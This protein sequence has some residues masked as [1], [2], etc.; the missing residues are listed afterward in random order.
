MLLIEFDHDSM[1]EPSERQVADLGSTVEWKLRYVHFEADVTLAADGFDTEN[2][3]VPVLDF[4]YCLLLSARAIR[5]GEDGRVTFTESDVV[6]DFVRDGSD[7]K[8]LRSW[9]PAPGHCGTDEFIA[10]V[11]RFT[12]DA[13]EFITGKYPAFCKNPTFQKLMTMMGPSVS[14]NHGRL[15][16]S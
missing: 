10:A 5:A 12:T 7:L 16:G 14:S 15:D 9:D 3:R 4:M 13:L 2:F 11:S 6:I 1:W 8:I